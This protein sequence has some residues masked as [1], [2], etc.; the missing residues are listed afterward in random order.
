MKQHCFLILFFTV[1]S[2]EVHARTVRFGEPCNKS[3]ICNTSGF[4]HCVNNVCQCVNPENMVYDHVRSIC[5]S[6]PGDTCLF[7]TGGDSKKGEKFPETTECDRNSHCAEDK[8]CTCDIDFILSNNGSCVPNRVY[9]ETCLM[10]PEG[11]HNCRPDRY[12]RCVEGRCGCEEAQ[13]FYDEARQECVA[14]EGSSCIGYANCVPNA[15][16]PIRHTGSYYSSTL[17]I[18]QPGF[19]RSPEGLC[20]ANFG[21]SC[22]TRDKRCGHDMMCKSGR[23][24]CKYAERQ[25]YDRDLNLCVSLVD[26]PCLIKLKSDE[27]TKTN[28]TFPCVKNAECKQIDSLYECRCNEGYIEG[29]HTCE[30]AYDQPCGDNFEE[31]CDRLAPLECIDGKCKC[32][33]E[34]LYYERNTSKCKALV[35]APCLQG[36]K[37]FCTGGS[38]CRATRNANSKYG[39]CRCSQG[40]VTTSGRK[41]VHHLLIR[42]AV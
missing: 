17:C 36:S 34:Y 12:L 10:D 23:C 21:E 40:Y 2:P 22:N 33:S 24:E 27:G 11:N 30:L 1:L 41:C 39:Q 8:I 20:L 16:C 28:I 6:R 37:D 31:P 18:C 9:G 29:D 42:G 14:R 26:S 38:D 3:N 19:S 25:K 7:D 5:V 13:A 15:A 4:L 32:S 35:G